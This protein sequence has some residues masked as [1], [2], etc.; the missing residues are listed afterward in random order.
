MR[1]FFENVK[2]NFDFGRMR[3]P[4]GELLTEAAKEFNK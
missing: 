4:I 2:K 3:L 1:I